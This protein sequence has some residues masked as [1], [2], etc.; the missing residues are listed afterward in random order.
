M[1]PLS[2]Q[3]SEYQLG[4]KEILG[5]KSADKLISELTLSGTIKK[6]PD[7]LTSTLVLTDVRMK[8]DSEDAMLVS[9]GLIG[10]ANVGKKEVFAQVKGLIT[11]TKKRGG[12]EM[13]VYLELD[14]DTYYYFHYSRTLMQAYSSNKEFNDIIMNEKEDERKSKGLKGQEP[15]TYVLS[16]KRKKDIFLEDMGY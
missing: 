3:N 13:H 16:S 4:L 6:L 14:E 7:E 8:W 12:D 11:L 9:E 15:Y 10:L 5:L 1:K 2:I